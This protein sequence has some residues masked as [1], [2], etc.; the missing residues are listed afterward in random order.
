MELE[1]RQQNERGETK[2]QEQNN[3][4]GRQRNQDNKKRHRINAK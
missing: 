3:E 1:Q 2:Q 4:A